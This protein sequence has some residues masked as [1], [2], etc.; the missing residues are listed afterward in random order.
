MLF[1]SPLLWVI[2]SLYFLWTIQFVLS[3]VFCWGTNWLNLE[4]KSYPW[5]LLKV[6]MATWCIIKHQEWIIREIECGNCILMC[7]TLWKI[8]KMQGYTFNSD[9][10]VNYNS[11]KVENLGGWMFSQEIS[12][13]FGKCC[14][15][16]PGQPERLMGAFFSWTFIYS[17]IIYCSHSIYKTLC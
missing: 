3:S 2:S 10:F 6:S 7:P 9:A 5:S 17:P 11:W 15:W 4:D 13:I 12:L 14:L 1:Y 8:F 16:S